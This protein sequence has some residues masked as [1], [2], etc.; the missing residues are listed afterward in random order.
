MSSGKQSDLHGVERSYTEVLKKLY[1][2][3][4]RI[5]DGRR[6]KHNAKLH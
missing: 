2:L 6:K 5:K 3:E 1:F 4:K